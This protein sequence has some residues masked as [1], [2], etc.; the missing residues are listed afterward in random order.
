[1]I[2]LFVI[3]LLLYGVNRYDVRALNPQKSERFYIVLC[4][5]FI[6]I[7]SFR[8]NIGGDTPNYAGFFNELPTLGDLNDTI[9]EQIRFQPGWVYFVS[10]LKT[11]WNDFVFQQIVEALFINIIVFRFIKRYSPY[12]FFSTLVYFLLNYFEY[13]TEILRE[14]LCVA[15]GLLIYELWEKKHYI[16][17]A[18]LLFIAFEIHVSALILFFFP[19]ASN[20]RI[21]KRLYYIS[22]IILLILPSLYMAIPNLR[23]Y[24][25]LIF[26]QEDWVNDNYLIQTF[27]EELNINF[28]INH[29]LRYIFIPFAIIYYLNKR[30][31]TKYTGMVYAYS[32]LQLLSMFS[33]AFY[34]FANYFAPFYWIATAMCMVLILKNTP[35][36]RMAII[37]AFLVVFLYLYQSVQLLYDDYRNRYFYERYIPYVTIFEGKG[38]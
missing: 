25:T 4:I 20:L 22:I 34:R 15:I 29:V 30:Q 1:M 38:Y 28:Y 31:E 8:Y 3:L 17:S 19:I 9:F 24:A 33:Y 32:V 27:A 10:T 18:I 37:S 2:Y 35:K 23:L 13:N 14:S 26:N 6:A 16:Y 36:I 7:P 21:T 11:I 5:L 12:I